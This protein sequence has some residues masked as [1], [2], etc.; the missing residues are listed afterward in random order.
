[1]KPFGQL[2]SHPSQQ[3]PGLPRSVDVIDGGIGCDQLQQQWNLGD[4][5]QYTPKESIKGAVPGT[6]SDQGH[7]N[8]IVMLQKL[9]VFWIL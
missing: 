8:S 4:T 3:P 1:M 2:S 6:E 7:T 9:E 5:P